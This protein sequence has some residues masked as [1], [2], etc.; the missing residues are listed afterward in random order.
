MSELNIHQRLAAAIKA[1]GA[2]PK[3]G[4]MGGGGGNFAYHK[5]DDVVDHLRDI[6][7]DAGIVILPSVKSCDVAE[8]TEQRED[9]RGKLYDRR[10]YHSTAFISV[11]LVNI[12][13]QDDFIEMVTVGDG[14]DYGDKSTGKA[15]SYAMKN[16][17]LSVFQLRGQPDNEDTDHDHA[18]PPRQQQASRPAPPPA[19]KP[20]LPSMEERKKAPWAV[21]NLTSFESRLGDW[22]AVNHHKRKD[23]ASQE[24]A[25]ETLGNLSQQEVK[26]WCDNWCLPMNP[27]KED[28]HLRVALN[29]ARKEFAIAAS[30]ETKPPDKAAW[31]P[32]DEEVPFSWIGLLLAAGLSAGSM[33]C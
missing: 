22:R 5:I 25:P 8:F 18:V 1:S 16:L 32:P 29:L 23:K 12:D 17:L 4:K 13:K 10:V 6:L 21:P 24:P 27:T 31:P 33:M 28:M 26:W 3:T 15:F 2:V 7:L 14:I 9:A 19:S 20:P 30:G 11:R